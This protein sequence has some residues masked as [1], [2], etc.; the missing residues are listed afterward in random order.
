MSLMDAPLRPRAPSVPSLEGPPSV[1]LLESV[2][3]ERGRRGSPLAVWLLAAL[4]GSSCGSAEADASEANEG[5]DAPAPAAEGEV[6]AGEGLVIL[7]DPEAEATV[8]PGSAPY[9]PY[10]HSF[11]T[12]REGRVVDHTFLLEN[13]DP[14]PVAIHRI[15]PA[16]GCVVP[17]VRY[18]EEDGTVVEGRRQTLLKPDEDLIVIPPGAVCELLIRI[19]SDKSATKNA[20]K[21]LTTLVTTD[22]PNSRYLQL[23]THI[24]VQK[25]FDLIPNGIDFGRVPLSGASTKSCEIVQAVGSDQEIVELVSHP[26][27]VDVSLEFQGGFARGLWRLTAQLQP[28]LASQTG[29]WTDE[30]VFSVIDGEGE[31]DEPL[32]LGVQADF[33]PDIVNVPARLVFV[34]RDGTSNGR[35]EVRSLL[36]GHRFGVREVVFADAAHAELFEASFEPVEGQ[37]APRASSWLLTVRPRA[38]SGALALSG[39]QR[40]ELILSLDDPQYPEVRVIYVIH[41]APSE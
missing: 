38:T 13:R 15:K 26:E 17:S 16:C 3:R 28:G 36:P 20:H 1:S 7:P 10:Y 24:F 4:A 29:R 31:P 35:V 11:G 33:S 14:N 6:V 37:T 12:V 27:G 32:V 23:E 2:R 9:R 41:P 25:R 39:V 40:G 34:A 5:T 8:E 19:E 22:S 30:I 21:T 18:R